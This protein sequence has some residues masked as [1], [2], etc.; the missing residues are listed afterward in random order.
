MEKESLKKY[1]VMNVISIVLCV[2]SFLLLYSGSFCKD[3]TAKSI[4]E[5]ISVLIYQFLT[6]VAV[7][8][9]IVA[10]VSINKIKKKIDIISLLVMIFSIL[11]ALLFI[12]FFIFGVILGAGILAIYLI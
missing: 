8:L 6:L 7:V 12:L 5:T 10:F 3:E 1:R 4:V 2:V 9:S 11:A